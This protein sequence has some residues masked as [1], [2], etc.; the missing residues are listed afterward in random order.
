MC[1]AQG[2]KRVVCILIRRVFKS[3]RL[4]HFLVLAGMHNDDDEFNAT[5]QVS[6]TIVKVSI[7]RF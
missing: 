5:V 7:S 1:L 4:Y 3:R 6:K 2:G